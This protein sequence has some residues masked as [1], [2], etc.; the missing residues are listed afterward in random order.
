M[1]KDRQ[2]S[3]TKGNNSINQRGEGNKNT[4][5]TTTPATTPTNTAV[6][7]EANDPEELP[8]MEAGLQVN[9]EAN[10]GFMGKFKAIF[11][12]GPKFGQNAAFTDLV[13]GDGVVVNIMPNENLAKQVLIVKPSNLKNVKGEITNVTATTFTVTAA[14]NT[15][16]TLK[17]DANTSVTIKGAVLMITG[18]WAQVVYNSETLIAKTINVR[19]EAPPTPTPT[20]NPTPTT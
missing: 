5:P 4:Q 17:W 13:V 7:D 10:Q 19:L 18:Q 9:V 3:K 14:D 2:D 15:N 16:M 12:R 1:K 11:N 20:P 8:E 6:I